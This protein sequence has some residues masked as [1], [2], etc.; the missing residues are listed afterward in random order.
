MNIFKFN[1]TLLQKFLIAGGVTVVGL[2]L[3]YLTFYII[4]KCLKRKDRIIP[5]LLDKHLHI[6]GL[7][8]IIVLTLNINLEIF[9]DDINIRAFLIIKHLLRIILLLSIGYVLMKTLSLFKNL[10]ITRVKRKES[11]EYKLRS[12]KTQYSLIQKILNFVIIVV[13]ISLILNTFSQVRYIGSTLLAS[14]GVGGI[15]LGFA[16]QKSLSSIIAGIQIAIA[17][18]FKIDDTIIVEGTL[19]TVKEISLTYVVINTWDEKRLI[20]PINYFLDTPFENWTRESQEIIATVKVYVDYTFPIEVTRK[21]FEKWL[22]STNLWD[23]RKSA[24]LITDANDKTIEVR[25]TMS[26]K[27]S[28]DAFDLECLIREK[29]INY[30]KEKH[31]EALPSERITVKNN[32]LTNPSK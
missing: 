1:L 4:K 11:H 6:A 30:I 8:F 16:A 5:V 25:A 32:S 22:D 19:G 10:I 27:N 23:K 18:P 21:E 20:V 7:L 26:V 2:L 14:A 24:L 12:V 29:L 15:V 28:D 31:P 9:K 13:V 3:F 17:Q